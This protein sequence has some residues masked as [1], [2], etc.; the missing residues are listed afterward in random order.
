MAQKKYTS[1]RGTG[2]RGTSKKARKP[3]NNLV[4][5]QPTQVKI[6]AVQVGRALE[7]A[8]PVRTSYFVKSGGSS[9]A[10]GAGS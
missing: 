9:P 2:K 10:D 6:D 1:K 8:G 3:F 5:G 7:V 4:G